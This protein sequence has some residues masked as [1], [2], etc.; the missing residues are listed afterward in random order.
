MTT[1]GA[2]L[3]SIPST[4]FRVEFFASAAA[5]PSGFGEGQTYLGFIS[6]TTD[7]AG[8]TVTFTFTSP[9]TSLAGKFIS[10]TAT[11]PAGNTSKFSR[12]LAIPGA[13]ANQP[14]VITSDLGGRVRLETFGRD[15][16]GIGS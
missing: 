11:D 5:D 1:I 2:T 7:T 14:P 3:N 4:T 8:N 13:P 16:I 15:Q 9:P 6:V 12:I 10:A